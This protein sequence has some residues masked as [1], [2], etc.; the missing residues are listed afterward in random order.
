MFITDRPHDWP[1]AIVAARREVQRSS[2]SQFDPQVVEVLLSVQ[3]DAITEGIF[4]AV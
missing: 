4:H 3:D 1:R 2:G